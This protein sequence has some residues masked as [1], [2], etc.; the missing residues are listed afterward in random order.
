MR[1]LLPT[2]QYKPQLWS[3][4]EGK[5]VDTDQYDI[6]EQLHLDNKLESIGQDTKDYQMFV[7]VPVQPN[8][9]A[10][11]KVVKTAKPYEF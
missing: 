8:E 10:F 11:V 5:F 4:K 7:N 3:K 6:F 1:I 2:S 9:V